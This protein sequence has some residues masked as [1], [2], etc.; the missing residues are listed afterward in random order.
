[1]KT[2][3]YTLLFHDRPLEEAIQVAAEAGYEG[4]EIMGREPHLPPGTPQP[5]A[6]DLKEMIDDA[7]LAVSCLAGYN[8]RYSVLETE[9]E[10]QQELDD[11]R[12]MLD[13]AEIFGCPLVRHRPGGPS[14]RKATPEQFERAVTW[15]AK[16]A[17]EANR[18]GVRIVLE[19]HFNHLVESAL[20]AAAMLG[21]IERSNVGVIHD[22]GNLFI[23]GHDF[24]AESVRLLGHSIYHVHVKD[25]KRMSQESP[26]TFKHGTSL[27]A[28][29]LLGEGDADHLPAFRA[30]AELGY[31]GYLSSEY[32]TRDPDKALAAQHELAAM[33]RLIEQATS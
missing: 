5:H 8:G 14:P 33:K 31:T 17:D 7:G 20:D 27:Y 3:L 23:G 29:S 6:L 22:A 32:Q 18:R 4:I 9:A 28:V 16:A 12:R 25:I 24:G 21:R 11:F 26:G 30:L 10:C 2:S 19:L 13:L 1:M 15:V